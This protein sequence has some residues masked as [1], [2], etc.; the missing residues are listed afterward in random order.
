MCPACTDGAEPGS[1]GGRTRVESFSSED[2]EDEA[3]DVDSKSPRVSTRIYS[4]RLLQQFEQKTAMLSQ[5]D[6]HKSTALST[7]EVGASSLAVDNLKHETKEL[8][9]T[10]NNNKHRRP[11]GR[12]PKN[13]VIIEPEEAAG[14]SKNCP[15]GELD[16]FMRLDCCN[17]SNVSPDSGIQSV[18]GSPVHQSCSPASNPPVHTSPLHNTLPLSTSPAP[19]HHSSPPKSSSPTPLH[20]EPKRRPGRPA[21]SQQLVKRRPGRPKG[22][23]SKKTLASQGSPSDQRPERGMLETEL[24][25][26]VPSSS[27]S[28]SGT[29]LNTSQPIKRGPGRPKKVIME[30]NAQLSPQ[31]N[32]TYKKINYSGKDRN[33][34]SEVQLPDDNLM[35]TSKNLESFLSRRAKK[36]HGL[37]TRSK[38]SKTKMGKR[39]KTKFGI[40]KRKS[41]KSLSTGKKRW[42]SNNIKALTVP[43]HLTND[44]AL[45][46]AVSHINH[47]YSSKSQALGN[48]KHSVHNKSHNAQTY[49]QSTFK[50][51]QKSRGGHKSFARHKLREQAAHGS[52]KSAKSL[53]PPPPSKHK[54]KKK[55]TGECAKSPEEDP[56][57]LNLLEDL[58]AALRKCSISR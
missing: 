39:S 4:S 34:K 49:H 52:R 25:G 22:S 57:F 24:P 17:V 47:K 8:K 31:Q 15:L 18:A 43:F 58:L 5:G 2:G 19:Q 27:P 32:S 14:G 1:S 30:S 55:N 26:Y 3:S 37:K 36:A 12:P 40:D 23:V 9:P 11:R 21:K 20:A 48:R 6:T 13:P 7:V 50:G 56:A 51:Q 45:T 54:K 29:Q 35:S 38:S 53:R 10:V 46:V 16:A 44:S 33:I 42:R 28:L 41:R